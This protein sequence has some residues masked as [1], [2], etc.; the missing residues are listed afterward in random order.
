[1][2]DYVIDE[3]QL[4]QKTQVQYGTVQYSTLRSI[5]VRPLQQ[6]TVKTPGM[7]NNMTVGITDCMIDD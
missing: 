4:L 5:G 2:T 7:T 3:N 1:M 6:H